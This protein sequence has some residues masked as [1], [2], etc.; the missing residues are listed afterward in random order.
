MGSADRVT[1]PR[2]RT[3]HQPSFRMYGQEAESGRKTT[4]EIAFEDLAI[5][6]QSL[7][8]PAWTNAR[9]HPNMYASFMVKDVQEKVRSLFRLEVNRTTFA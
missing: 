9:L 8:E 4:Q 2:T 3:M 5:I 7:E 1:P 6:D